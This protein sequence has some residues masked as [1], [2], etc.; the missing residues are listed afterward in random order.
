M[1]L[2]L[3]VYVIEPLHLNGSFVPRIYEAGGTVLIEFGDGLC[4][5][6]YSLLDGCQGTLAEA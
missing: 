2:S 3:G 4:T 5:A 6:K 1:F